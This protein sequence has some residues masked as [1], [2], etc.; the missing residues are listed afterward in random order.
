VETCSIEEKAELTS[1]LQRVGGLHTR[2]C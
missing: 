1:R 2:L